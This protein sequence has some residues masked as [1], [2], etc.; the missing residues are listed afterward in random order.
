MGTNDQ[1]TFELK[2]DRQIPDAQLEGESA[3]VQ[4]NA[5]MDAGDPMIPGESLN[6][7]DCATPDQPPSCDEMRGKENAETQGS[8]TQANDCTLC[9]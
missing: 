8:M 6:E 9:G 7:M 1:A 2:T 3:N 4:E 5:V